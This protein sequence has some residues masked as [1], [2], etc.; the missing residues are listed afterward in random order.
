MPALERLTSAFSDQTG[1]AVDF[2]APKSSERLQQD[3]ETALYRIVQESLTNV[4]KHARAQSVSVPVSQ[5]NGKVSA[6]VEDDGIGSEPDSVREGGFGLEGMR[7]RL[8]LVGGRLRIE[9]R[10]DGSG[11]TIAVEVPAK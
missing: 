9:S 2:Q 5:R 11:T 6:V 7:E 4:V 3:V 8:A 10:A 1:I